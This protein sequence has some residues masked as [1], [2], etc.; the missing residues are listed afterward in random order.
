MTSNT[1]TD[2]LAPMDKELGK[3][4]LKQRMRYQPEEIE[5]E[6]KRIVEQDFSMFQQTN[7][8]FAIR[9]SKF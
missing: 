7:P 3:K 8:L 5:G 9:R 2:R 6:Q 4:K 1:V